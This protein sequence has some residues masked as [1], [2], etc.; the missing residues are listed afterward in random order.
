MHSIRWDTRDGHRLRPRERCPKEFIKQEFPFRG[1]YVWAIEPHPGKHGKGPA[2]EYPHYHMALARQIAD[3]EG[4]AA[5]ILAWWQDH[6]VDIAGPGV[7][8]QY[9]RGTESVAKYV[10][11]YVTKGCNDPLWSAMGWLTGW[12]FWGASRVLGNLLTNSQPTDD[13]DPV[14]ELIG[15][16]PTVM[17]D[18][19]MQDRPPPEDIA[20]IAGAWMRRQT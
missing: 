1:A 11:K 5:W 18:W 9:T 6:G 3:K 19:I 17:L 8:V 10:T 13:E 7:D 12:R 16:V 20:D 14:W 4:L 15:V 2:Y